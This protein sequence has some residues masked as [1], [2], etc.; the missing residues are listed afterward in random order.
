MSYNNNYFARNQQQQQ[1]PLFILEHSHALQ[2]RCELLTLP[3]LP[4]VE[5]ETPMDAPCLYLGHV[6][7]ECSCEQLRW[8]ISET[9]RVVALKVEVRGKGGY[10]VFL[11][12]DEDVSFVRM[13][14]KRILFDHSGVWFARTNDQAELLAEYAAGLQYIKRTRFR[15]PRDAMTVEDAKTR[16]QQFR[17]PMQPTVNTMMMQQQQQQQQMPFQYATNNNFSYHNQ[18]QYPAALPFSDFAA[19]GQ[20]ISN[21]NNLDSSNNNSSPFFQNQQQ[22]ESPSRYS[23]QPYTFQTAPQQQQQQYPVAEAIFDPSTTSVQQLNSSSQMI[24]PMLHAPLPQRTTPSQPVAPA[25]APQKK[26]PSLLKQLFSFPTTSAPRPQQQQQV[27]DSSKLFVQHQPAVLPTV[28]EA[29]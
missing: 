26:V 23:H 12:S 4:S 14:H 3:E 19:L 8:L 27:L 1:E 16:P 22:P 11:K 18:H 21:N 5:R 9:S 10:A 29:Q 28:Q 13:L 17:Q 15:L 25:S 2:G 6:R 24:M 7:F 20:V